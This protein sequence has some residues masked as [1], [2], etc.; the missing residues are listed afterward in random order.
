MSESRSV[1]RATGAD[2]AERRESVWRLFVSPTIWAVHFIACYVTAAIW[3]EKFADASGDLG[4]AGTAIGVYTIVGL[5]AVG[6][7]GWLAYRRHRMSDADTPHDADTPRARSGFVAFATMLLA[8]LSA[9]AILFV[10]VA[11]A[12]AGSCR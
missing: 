2:F 3:C 4:A 7:D 10:A 11:A 9:V 1:H 8:G 5:A 6:I 12:V